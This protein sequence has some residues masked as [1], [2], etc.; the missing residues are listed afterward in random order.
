[1]VGST[2]IPVGRDGSV[3]ITLDRNFDSPIT[4]RA[5]INDFI[6]T[7]WDFNKDNRIPRLNITLAWVGVH[8]LTGKRIYFV[9]TMDPTGDTND[10]PFNTTVIVSQFFSYEIDHF[11]GQV[12]RSAGLKTYGD[13][14]YIFYKM[15][16][17]Y[18]NI[19]VTTVTD[20]RYDPETEQT[21][22][23]SKWPGRTDA[24]V[25][26]EIKIDWTGH[27]SPP[28]V[29]KGPADE[30]NDRVVLRVYMTWGGQP[31]T[32]PDLNPIGTATLY[33]TCGPV[34]IDLLTWAHTFWQRI[35]DGD[36]DYL[37]EARRIGNATYHIVNDNGVNME[38]YIPSEGVFSSSFTSKWTEDT[39]LTTWLKADSQHSSN[40]WWN[41]TYR[42]QD[43]FFL[44]Y[45]YPLQFTRGEEPWARFYNKVG[46]TGTGWETTVRKEA[47]DPL[48]LRG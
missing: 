5:V 3:T 8:P 36:F 20:Q 48:S 26:Y 25:D 30:V 9:E 18:Y 6:F 37:R 2:E 16:S 1:M 42:K 17:T 34:N 11:F 21:P 38:Q 31:V 35:V 10:D 19:T 13:V 40:I 24:E 41:G 27:N 32:D 14:R 12:S 43:L 15:P 33:T 39:L 22:G 46:L 45:V 29:R 23:N 44:S 28:K 47:D 7:T 4:L